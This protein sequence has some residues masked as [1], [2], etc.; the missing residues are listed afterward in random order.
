MFPATVPVFKSSYDPSTAPGMTTEEKEREAGLETQAKAKSTAGV[1]LWP[2]LLSGARP[3]GD[4]ITMIDVTA[5]RST[6]DD[7]DT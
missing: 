4:S 2:R 5:K 3:G 1:G 7:D 6:E